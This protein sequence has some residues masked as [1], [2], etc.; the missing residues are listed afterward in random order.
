MDIRY[1]DCVMYGKQGFCRRKVS[2]SPVM[3]DSRLEKLWLLRCT[4]NYG[5]R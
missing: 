1:V 4:S 5:P 3:I 2:I